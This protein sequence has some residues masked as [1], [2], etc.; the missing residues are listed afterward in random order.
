MKMR[1][2]NLFIRIK[3]IAVLFFLISAFASTKCF[4]QSENQTENNGGFHKSDSILSELPGIDFDYIST[5]Q[6]VQYQIPLTAYF[7]ENINEIPNFSESVCQLI[8]GSQQ[9][10]QTLFHYSFQMLSASAGG[11]GPPLPGAGQSKRIRNQ[12]DL[13]KFFE[14]PG[15]E[16]IQKQEWDKLPFSFRKGIVEILWS[17]D[18]A[19]M[20]FEQFSKPVQ[21]YLN[22]KSAF[23]I[24]EMY[25]ELML[26]WNQR[27]L[28]ELSSLD[29]IEDADLKKLSFGT[30]KLTEKLNWFFMQKELQIPED[31][32]NCSINSCM[33]K[34]LISGTKNDTI[35]GDQFF[36]VELGGDDVYLGNTA[37]TI[38]GDQPLGIVVDLKGNDKYLSGDNYLVA[39]ILGMAVLLDLE[40]DDLY[41]TNKPG[42]AFSLYGSSLLYDYSGNDKYLGR[43]YCQAASFIGASLL[44]DI[45]GDDKYSCQSNSQA[46]GG[47]LG[48]GI[49]YDNS[50]NDLYNTGNE[51]T[52]DNTFSQSF[53][54]GAAKGRWAEATDGQ[55][56]AGGIGIFI[57]NSGIDRYAAGSFSQGASYYFGLG[58]FNDNN[59]DDEYNAISH[60][61]GYAA[62]YSLAGFFE[63]TGDD[64]YNVQSPKDKITQI[65]GGG[66]DFSAG[67]FFEYNGDDTYHFGNRS[68]GIGDIN[69][70]GLLADL[71]GNDNYI[72][73]KN[74]LNSG[75][76]SLGKEP[77]LGES[78]N[79]GVK[80]F[81]PKDVVHKGIFI[82][83]KGTNNFN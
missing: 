67:L 72:W 31:F 70:I 66:R 54:Q 58:L 47:T 33:G 16:I 1:K 13:D 49:F 73:H 65:I 59:G 78:M 79:I 36:V 62:H 60:S 57:D 64:M 4:C 43:N 27:E 71:K 14:I 50:G 23:I 55:S 37:S 51:A 26:P 35:K 8:A 48:V 77:G 5:I 61:Q 81:Q 41:Q 56:L 30:R 11:F 80:I 76:Q 83:S 15:V 20:I 32:T 2:L 21:E 29:L 25:D 44:I 39:G 12:N 24:S 75:S 7:F 68:A 28:N 38:S 82:D 19:K 40:G 74:S 63:Q 46:F 3:Q 53:I 52:T 22:E 6:D 69:G 34:L 10:L 18:E 9:N 42:L 45:S 17:V